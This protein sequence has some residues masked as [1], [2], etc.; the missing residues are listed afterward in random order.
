MIEEK[1]KIIFVLQQRI[2]ELETKIQSMIALPDYN[3]EKQET[4]LEKQKLEERVAKLQQ[5]IQ[6]EK[7]KSFILILF[8]L[9]FVGIA[10][11]LLLRYNII[12]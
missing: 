11:F 3:R 5:A 1:N 12:A 9:V 7:T 2:G 8:S 6:S 4:L 10:L